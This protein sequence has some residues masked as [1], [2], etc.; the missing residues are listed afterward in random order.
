MKD[1]QDFFKNI[2]IEIFESLNTSY[3]IEKT[4]MS[5]NV[6][7]Y[8]INVNNKKYRIFIENN[9]NNLHVGFERYK[10]NKWVT[11]KETHDLSTKEILG[12]FGTIK[13]LVKNQKMKS[14]TVFSKEIQKNRIYIKM[15]QK[16]NNELGGLTARLG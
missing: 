8:Y 9:K 15:I 4:E 11:Q 2:F 1:H 6:Q 7:L 14:L 10:N 5:N 3:N 13:K 12:L 16:L